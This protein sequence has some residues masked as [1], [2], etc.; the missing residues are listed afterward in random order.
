MYNDVV[1]LYLQVDCAVFGHLSQIMFVDFPYAHKDMFD[2][3]CI[4]L[5]HYLYRIRDRLWPD[6]FGRAAPG[7]FDED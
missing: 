3:E 5:R 7:E 6:W 1:V 4:N 2:E